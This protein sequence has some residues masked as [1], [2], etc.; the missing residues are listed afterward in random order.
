MAKR[1]YVLPKLDILAKVKRNVR[2]GQNPAFLLTDAE[3]RKITLKD[4]T[5]I[6]RDM[7]KIKRKRRK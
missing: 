1:K 2:Y 3:K 7:Y 5:M 4:Y 6:V